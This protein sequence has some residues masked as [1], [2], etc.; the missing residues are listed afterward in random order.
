MVWVGYFT[1]AIAL[2]GLVAI[3]G[4]TLVATGGYDDGVDQPKCS[5]AAARSARRSARVPVALL[6][7][8][9][10]DPTGLHPD[11]KAGEGII[12]HNHVPVGDLDPLDNRLAQLSAIVFLS[13][14]ALVSG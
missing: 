8:L 3:L 13:G 6:D 11:P 2:D 14:H 4:I 1:L 5:P 7:D 12:P 10:A 9:A